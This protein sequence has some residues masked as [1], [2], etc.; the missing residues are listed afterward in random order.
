MRN[1]G[2]EF[3][4]TRVIEEYHGKDKCSSKVRSTDVVQTVAAIMYCPIII[5]RQCS[6]TNNADVARKFFAILCL[7]KHNHDQS[8]KFQ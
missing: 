5:I 4:E 8:W 1:D 3:P 2:V 7:R 6:R